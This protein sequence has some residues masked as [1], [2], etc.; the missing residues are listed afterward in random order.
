M[1]KVF[2]TAD[3]HFQHKNILM[4]QANR[5]FDSIEEMD[6]FIIQEWNKQVTAKDTVY[7][8]G[9]VSFRG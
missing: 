1:S 5:E 2:V 9:D 8:L 7:I 6:E 4:H 3:L